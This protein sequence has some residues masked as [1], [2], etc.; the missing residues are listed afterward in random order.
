MTIKQ[1]L[2]ISHILMIIVP[3]LLSL[4]ASVIA[5]LMVW[6]YFWG[7]D[8]GAMIKNTEF[9]AQYA[10][11]ES[12]VI[13]W[14]TE[15]TTDAEVV[16]DMQHFKKTNHSKNIALLVYRGDK[17]ISSVGEVTDQKM[18]ETALKEEGEHSYLKDQTFLTTFDTSN[19][20]IILINSNYYNDLYYQDPLWD[21]D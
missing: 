7:L 18:K 12:L 5:F 10:T 17:L 3:V 13:K 1:R 8:E 16:A 14:D 11:V 6:R 20:K 2:F 9:R 4:L 15:K 19:Y 21:H